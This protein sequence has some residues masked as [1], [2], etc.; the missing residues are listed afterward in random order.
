[1]C[2]L[3]SS[4]LRKENSILSTPTAELEGGPGEGAL[5]DR[6]SPGGRLRCGERMRGN[7]SAA[8]VGAGCGA[9]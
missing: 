5:G 2:M 4:L 9:A 8:G 6:A 7:F 1:M 3:L